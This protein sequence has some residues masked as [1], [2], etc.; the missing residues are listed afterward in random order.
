MSILFPSV[1]PVAPAPVPPCP[2][3]V[4]CNFSARGRY[5]HHP[6]LEGSGFAPA[7]ASV[8]GS[9]VPAMHLPARDIVTRTIVPLVPS[10]PLE[11]LELQAG[12]LRPAEIHLA[13]FHR[14]GLQLARPRS[15]LG[16][17]ERRFGL[18]LASLALVLGSTNSVASSFCPGT[19]LGEECRIVNGGD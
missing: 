5:V 2:P 14:V 8:I 4:L 6:P 19:D 9:D 10:Q 3:P 17:A 11:F 13:E 18:Q 7:G 1:G 15:H 16:V 12:E